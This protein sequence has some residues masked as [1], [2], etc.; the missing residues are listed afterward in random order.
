SI[1]PC[2]SRKNRAK[3]AWMRPT[4][5]LQGICVVICP[6]LTMVMTPSQLHRHCDVLFR[7]GAPSISTVGDPGTQGA[8]VAGMHGMGVRT[9]RAAAVA[10]ATVGF[11]IEVHIPN[12]RMFVIGIWSMMLA[13]SGPPSI[14]RWIG[15]TTSALGASPKLH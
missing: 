6:G 8:A 1:P 10:A 2:P 9:P 7:A 15:K 4:G 14:T 5:L 3:A 13:A 12:G 11:A